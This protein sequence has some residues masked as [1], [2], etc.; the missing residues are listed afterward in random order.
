MAVNADVPPIWVALWRCLFGALALAAILVAQRAAL[1][2]DRAT[3]GHALVV[4]L[5]LN[6]LP[7]ALLAYGETHVSSLLVGVI[8]A[9]TPLPPCSSCCCWSHRNS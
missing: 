2:R 5:F 6:S 4:A 9:T 3:W 1:P 7:F 8:N